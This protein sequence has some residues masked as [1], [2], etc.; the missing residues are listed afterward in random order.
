MTVK[1]KNHV[2]WKN[3]ANNM[4]NVGYFKKGN[5]INLGRRYSIDN[6]VCIVCRECH[7]LTDSYGGKV[8]G[9]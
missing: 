7:K 9:N 8:N 2:K 5:T 3:I 4:N 6:C 1:K